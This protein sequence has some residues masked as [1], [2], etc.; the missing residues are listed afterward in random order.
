MKILA[1][2]SILTLAICISCNEEQTYPLEG[3]WELVKGESKTEDS[4]ISYPMTPH[5]K[6]MKLLTKTHF[7]TVAMDTTY[8]H[9]AY[10]SFNGGTY[11]LANGIYTER[12]EYL[13]EPSGLGS[14]AYFKIKIED[15]KFFI[16]PANED[17]EEEEYGYFEEWKRANL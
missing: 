10:P 13:S 11:T 5:G 8:P 2:C 15:D 7:T 16:S 14:I 1:I 9:P 12:L 17:G 4:T 6:H 3:A